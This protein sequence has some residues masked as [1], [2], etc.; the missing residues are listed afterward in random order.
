M[1]QARVPAT[2]Q[3][4]RTEEVRRGPLSLGLPLLVLA[5]CGLA[6]SLPAAASADLSICS[7][8]TTAGK[9]ENAQGL[10]IDFETGRLYVADRGNRRVDVFE[11]GPEHKFAFAF[12]WG[13]A[14]GEPELQSCGPQATPPTANCLKGLGGG[15]AGALDELS[16][17]AVDNDPASPSQHDVYVLDGKRIQKFDD[18]GSFLLTFG[19]GVITGGASGTGNLS[20]GSNQ[21]TAVQT[22]AKRFA[23]GQTIVGTGIPAGT[24]I[25]ALG[26]E[27]ITL[28]NA[29]TAS[30]TGVALSVAAGAGNKPAN[31]VDRLVNTGNGDA[32][33][34][35]A[36]SPNFRFNT[37]APNP[38]PSQTELGQLPNSTTCPGL[39]AAFEALPNVG[40]GNVACIG[41]KVEGEVHEYTVEFKGPRYSDTDVTLEPGLSNGVRRVITVENGGGAAEI[42]TAAIAAS[43]SAGIKGAGHGQ[44]AEFPH[45]AV[46]PGGVVHVADCMPVN[47]GPFSG[48]TCKN[49]LQKFEPSGDFVEEL[50]LPQTSSAPSGLAV[51][52]AGD[53]YVSVNAAIRKYDPAGTLLKELAAAEGV[54]ALAVD[55][56]DDLFS[57]ERE[58]GAGIGSSVIA[59]YDP[60]G[61]TLRRFGYGVIG[62][63]DGL[64]PFQSATG[65]LFTAEDGNVL[66]RSFPPP[67][68]IVVAEPC[69]TSF[70]GNSKATL[71]ARVNPEGKATTVHFEYVDQKSFEDGGGFA[72]KNTKTTAESASIGSDFFLHDAEGQADLVPETKYHCRVIATNADAPGGVVGQEGTFTS[73][74]PLELGTTTVSGVGTET[75]TLN[76]TVNPLGISASGHFEYVEEATYE[77]DI[78]ELG[79]GHGFD[80]AAKAPDVDAS[81]APIDFG[82]GESLKLGSAQLTGLKPG[83]SYRFRIVA[84]DV[85]ISPEGKEVAGPAKGFRTFGAAPGALPDERAWELVSPAQKDSADVA[86]PVSNTSG[87]VDDRFV[88]IQAGATSGEAVTYTSWTSFGDADGAP[89]T[90]QYLSR[91][92]ESGWQTEN[93]SPFGFIW[94]PLIPPFS[95]FSPDLRFGAVKTTEPVLSADCREGLESLYLRDNET[96]ELHCLS[97]EAP[98]APDSACL[99]YAGASE[100]GGRAFFAGTPEGGVS[101]TYSLYEWSEAS[102]VQLVSVLPSGEAALATSGTAFGPGGTTGAGGGVEGCQTNRTVLRHAISADGSR[103]FWTYV[104]EAN[105]EPTQL[106]ARLNGSET[107]Q[108]DKAANPKNGGNGVFRAASADGSVAYFTDEN[109]LLSGANPEKGRPDLYR[110]QFGQPKALTLTDLTKGPVPGDVRGVVGAS[111]DGSYL[112]FVAGAVLSPDPNKAGQVAEAGKNNLYLHHA[113]VTS[114]IAVEPGLGSANP[115]NMRAR[116]SADG[117]HLAFLSTEAE[118]LA[119]YDNTIAAGEHCQNNPTSDGKVELVGSPLCPQAFLYEADSGELHCASCNPSGARPL[120]PTALPGWSNGFEGPRFLSDDGQRLF[121]QSFD[122]LVPAD[123]NGKGD[124]YEFER[125]G[126]GSCSE[127]DESFDPASGGCQFLLSSGQSEDESYLVD[128]SADGRDVFI[129]TRQA[130][131]GWDENDHYDVYDVREGGGFPEPLPAPP[132]CAGEACKAPP[133]PAPPAGPAPA[134][135]SFQ[136]PGNVSWPSSPRCPKGKARRKGRCVKARGNNSDRQKQTHRRAGGK[137]RAAR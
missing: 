24:K 37:S 82:T 103:A 3:P 109:T 95:G 128:A 49:R 4:R 83:T 41:E 81:E 31:E 133:S 47:G 79:P 1:R 84:T 42:C 59:E 46:G 78:E 119:G 68:P 75:A 53:F 121:F 30:G 113:G 20:S 25:T 55:A 27:T 115:R 118:K 135:P 92:S 22:T 125:P 124:I 35:T 54:G 48:G 63:A 69:K 14:N 96:G 107:V 97:L 50:A 131:V 93:I 34:I 106:Y 110:Y 129:T 51:D 8:G 10:A 102:G 120:G 104:P 18:E 17:V 12:G 65:D 98:G 39:Q 76:A 91:R 58:K 126:S 136:G 21:I 85:L 11:D 116:V 57:A 19:G 122:A 38:P 127:A 71:L 134:T 2:R 94:F 9:C 66:Y 23:V 73:K 105:G 89:A 29:A 123:E 70:L 130:L 112:Y 90:S 77:K 16:E 86:V 40:A 132:T 26:S 7:A 87:F 33:P 13:V 45:L 62:G 60:A 36:A 80:H 52:S 44:L 28:S 137:G 61:N 6:L 111:D 43:C 64:T 67:G 108:L 15:G 117:R 99:V 100:D 101:L 5:L 88:R 114:F 74:A 32:T 56:S 72:S